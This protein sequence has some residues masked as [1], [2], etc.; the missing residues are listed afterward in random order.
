MD[1]ESLLANANENMSTKFLNA[2]DALIIYMDEEFKI[3]WL[4][5]AAR[6]YF[7]SSGEELLDKKCYK[8]WGLSDFCPG[9]PVMEAKQNKDIEKLEMEKPGDKTWKMK[10]IPEINE[11]EEVEGFIEI[12]LDKTKK[13]ELEEVRNLLENLVNQ[14]PGVTY[15]LKLFPDGSSAFP[16]A[17]EGINEIYEVTSKEVKDD[18][19]KVF[20]RIHPDDQEKVESSIQKSAENLTI[21]QEEYRVILPEKGVRWVKGNARPEKLDDGSV[22]WHGNINDITERK[23]KEKKLEEIS[24]YDPNSGLPN[25]SSLIKNAN[26]LINEGKQNTIHLVVLD[27]ENY[28]DIMKAINHTRWGEFLQEVATQLKERLEINFILNN[29]ET[30]NKDW[31]ISVYNIYHNK[32]GFLLVNTPRNRL[33]K[34]VQTIKAIAELPF[35]YN[36]ISLF[37]DPHLGAASHKQEDSGAELLQ[38]AYHAMVAAVKENKKVKFNQ[39]T[40]KDKNR[41]NFQL[42]GEIKN[43]LAEDQ[44]KLYYMPKVKLTTGEIVG[45][46]AL[47]RWIHPEEGIVSPG[48]FIPH[49][50][51]TGL[52]D[53]LSR[54]VVNET[55]EEKLILAESGVDVNMAINISPNNLKQ[56]DFVQEIKNIIAEKNLSSDQF[57]LELTET[58]IMEELTEGNNF[59]NL[60]MEEGFKIA[61]DDFGTGYSSLAYLKNLDIDSIKIDLSF[62]QPMLEDKKSYEIVKTAVRLGKILDKE[63]VAE[64]IESEEVMNELNNLGCDYGQGFHICKPVPREKFVDFYHDWQEHIYS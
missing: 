61:M 8:I 41:K 18:A 52:I 5:K 35:Y 47:I 36:E 26:E 20:Q 23:K 9:C 64:G 39:E 7:A 57:E 29:K 45:A 21:W 37:L 53:E 60:L 11:E 31:E 13:R 10:V 16:Y 15:Q 24:L 43:A 1:R 34:F 50:E 19:S 33:S 38:N 63:V 58:E 3:K 25:S 32:L 62:I 27:I 49:I 40:L 42:L 14:A 48:R 17:S 4:N 28:E 56:E 22:L 55:A 54:W 46:E 30:K 59:L 6:E 44:F 2:L 12:A 51:K